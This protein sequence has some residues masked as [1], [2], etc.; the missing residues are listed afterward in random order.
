M[1]RAVCTC[2]ARCTLICT[3][4][5]L[6][7][8]AAAARCCCCCTLL[9]LLHAAAAAAAAAR[10][11][12]LLLQKAASHGFFVNLDAVL[13][14]LCGPFLDPGSG[15]FWKRVD[16]S[17]VTLGGRLNFKEVC[18]YF[19]F[20]FSDPHPTTSLALPALSLNLAFIS[21]HTARHLV[22]LCQ[23]LK[24]ILSNCL[25]HLLLQQGC[26]KQQPTTKRCFVFTVFASIALRHL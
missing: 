18:D 17:Y 3:P 2:F 26:C 13:L 14:K 4:P 1:S 22:P 6:P 16:P 9:L 20:I 21:Q 10:C 23:D 12:S 24:R 25:Q 5:L 11:W 15:V 8:A 19:R 7:A